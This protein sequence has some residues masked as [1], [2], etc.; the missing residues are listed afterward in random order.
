METNSAPLSSFDHD[1][2]VNRAISRASYISLFVSV[3]L[4]GAKFWAF[5]VT[6]S[7]AVLSDAIESI[8]NVIAAAMAIWGIA[9]A[10]KPADRDHPYG[11]GKIEFFSAAFEGGLITFASLVIVVEAIRAFVQGSHPQEMG[12][13]VGVLLAAG[14]GNALLGW[15]LIRLGRKHGS[16]AIEASGQHVVSDFWTSAGVVLGLILVWLTGLHWLD[17]LVALIVGFYL[18]WTGVKLVRSSVGGLLDAEDLEMLGYL[19]KIFKARPAGIIQV[20]HC[21][22]IRSGRYH[23]IDAHAVVPEFWNVSVAHQRT[24]EFEAA[25]VREYPHSGELHLHMD[26]CRR[27]YCRQCDV[28]ECPIRRENFY[29]RLDL[30]LEELTAPEEPVEF[31]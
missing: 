20:H 29:H 25:V 4:L 21:R 30:T 26:P 10:N 17:P 14:V 15:Y 18:S 23:H 3:V 13:G 19:V 12:W 24:E 7:Q 8:V 2:F 11:H 5:H 22:V 9:F 27:A 6:H 28:A 31:L 16:A 1:Q